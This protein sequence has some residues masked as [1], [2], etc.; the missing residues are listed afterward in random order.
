MF[1][2]QG[3]QV[4]GMGG[5]LVRRF[6]VF[7]EAFERVCGGFEGL[8]P[9]SLAG[10]VAGGEGL[11]ETGWAQ[12]GLFAFEVA[13]AE[14]LESWGVRAGVL[15]GH[16]L[17]EVVAAFRAGVW[18]LPDACRVVAARGRLMQA[19]PAGGVMVSVGVGEERVRSVLGPGVSVAAVNGAESV[20]VSG[21]EQA[22]EATVAGLGRVRRLRVSHAFH[23]VLMEPMLDEF[24]A[25]LASVEFRVPVVP[26]VS[27][28]TGRV[29]RE[30]FA[31][32]RYWLSHVRDTVRFADGVGAAD[33]DLWV[34]VGPRAVLTGLIRDLGVEAVPLAG[35][36]AGVL[37]GVGE[38]LARGGVVDWSAVVGGG[39][40]GAAVEVPTYAFDRRRYW[41][42]SREQSPSGWGLAGREHPV[43]GV[44][45]QVAGS[46]MRVLSGRVPAA[47]LWV[48]HRVGS[49]VLFPGAGFVDLVLAAV[50]GVAVA[51]LML[52]QPL[53]LDGG[54][55]VQVTVAGDLVEVNAR[56]EHAAEWTRHVTARIDDQPADDGGGGGG[57]RWEWPA[58]TA[59]VDVAQWYQRLASAGYDYG[60]GFATLTRLEHTEGHTYA[61]VSVEDAAGFEVHPAL[62]DGVFHAVL[63]RLG[64]DQPRVPFA[65]TGITLHATG[66]TGLRARITPTGPD[67]VRL[68]LADPA[69]E[70]VVTI[71]EVVLRALVTTGRDL[72]RLTWTPVTTRSE[73]PVTVYT[74]PADDAYQAV[75]ATLSTLQE[76]L[77]ADDDGVLAVHTHHGVTVEP[78]EPVNQAHAAVTG[79]VRTAQTENPGR[80]LLIDTDTPTPPE[81]PPT[82][83]PQTATRN[84]TTY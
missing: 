70:P 8:L 33:V 78:G 13:L 19:L 58:D 80:I 68:E 20:V 48:D 31:D 60:P 62:L 35:E 24:A 74:P 21:P 50:D 3:A 75:T 15:M 17:G 11:D 46:G 82:N 63:H 67:S 51:D 25:V 56:A 4:S 71:D 79:L 27:N 81:H 5:E 65:L 83:H 77:A 30:L 2:G 66:A 39:G 12:A 57:G 41:L 52:H 16:S 18:S 38:V 61:E 69:G 23:S 59:V 54:H 14:L 6:P 44:E 49:Q 43:L 37:A 26:V 9:G 64:I 84:T 34:E 72:H 22:V 42:A 28:V 53:V 73:G 10:V 36:V 32:P 45:T 29:E 40:S 76:W 47:G 7:R 1:S 55:S